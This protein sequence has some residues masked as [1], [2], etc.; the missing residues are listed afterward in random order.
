[1][2]HKAPI[3]ILMLDTRF[4]RIPGDIGNTAS[5][6]F[7]ILMERVDNAS[8]KRVV[9][10]DPA[11]LLP[12]FIAAGERLAAAGACAI[13][14]SCGFLTVFQREL[15]AA[16]PVPVATSSL[17]QVASVNA[18]LPPGKRAGVLTISGATLSPAHLHAAGVP[19]GTPIG[20]TEAGREF[21]Q[22]ILE[23]RETLD[24]AQA[25]QDILEAALALQA[26]H[27]DLGAIILECTNMGPYAPDIVEATGLPVFS[28][29]T[30]LRWLHASLA[31]PSF[32]G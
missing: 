4:P 8:P 6:P 15:A 24:V 21:T 29:L 23:D 9:R 7:P 28:I 11:A 19:V 5:W 14:T 17:L 26:T 12:D 31:P 27:P 25:R 32:T 10:G 13:T 30:Y 18:L 22:A 20:S 2:P 3:G 16:L 1:M